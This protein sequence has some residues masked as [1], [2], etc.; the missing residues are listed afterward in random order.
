M[1]VAI[2]PHLASVRESRRRFDTSSD[3]AD[4]QEKR[5]RVLVCR[6]NSWHGCCATQ[7]VG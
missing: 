3:P 7:L 4:V 1:T 2:L 6:I 5:V